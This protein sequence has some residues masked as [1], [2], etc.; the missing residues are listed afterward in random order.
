MACP[1]CSFGSGKIA[2]QWNSAVPCA[3]RF[4]HTGMVSQLSGKRSADHS[5]ASDVGTRKGRPMDSTQS[6]NEPDFP[7]DGKFAPLLPE[8]L[9]SAEELLAKLAHEAAAANRPAD[10]AEAV[11]SAGSRPAALSSDIAPGP[12]GNDQ[13]TSEL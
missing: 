11:F 6:L 12:R 2:M 1:L 13:A 3:S 8:N 10:M 9:A 7:R 5:R 4:G